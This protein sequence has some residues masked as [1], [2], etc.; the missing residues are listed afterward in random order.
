MVAA[1]AVIDEITGGTLVRADEWNE[2]REKLILENYCN[3]APLPI[4]KAFVEIA[5]RRGLPPEEK[6]I[7]L[8]NYG[9]TW[10]VQTAIDGYRAIAERS[11]RYAGSSDPVFVEDNPYPFKA[12]ITVK[13]AMDGGAIAEFS[14]SA[15]WAEYYPGDG[16]RGIMWRKM[17]HTMLAKCAEALAL[18]KAFPADLSGIY[19]NEEMHQADNGHP[20]PTTIREQAPQQGKKAAPKAVAPSNSNGQSSVSGSGQWTPFWMA[21]RRKGYPNRAALEAA[22]GAPVPSEITEAQAYLEAVPD[23]TASKEDAPKTT[24]K[25]EP[26][27]TELMATDDQRQELVDLGANLGLKVEQVRKRTGLKTL[28]DLTA[29]QFDNIF[30]ELSVEL[31]SVQESQA[32]ADPATGELPIDVPAGEAGN[33]KYSS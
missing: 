14:A 17:P 18:R 29:N 25:A 2:A 23:L 26:V 6:Q 27:E 33:D 10:I 13:K 8:V 20:E 3:N 22:A 9:G 21:V 12:T 19:T 11:G 15:F 1:V 32:A 5:K 24:A 30:A 16:N 31:E 4:A 7:Y 28:A